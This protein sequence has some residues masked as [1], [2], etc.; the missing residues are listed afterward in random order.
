MSASAQDHNHFPDPHVT[1]PSPQ[2]PLLDHVPQ[3]HSHAELPSS[4]APLLLHPPPPPRPLPPLV[5]SLCTSSAHTLHF[6]LFLPPP[7]SLC[8]PVLLS[9]SSTPLRPSSSSPPF[10][11]SHPPAPLPTP[12]FQLSSLYI[13]ARLTVRF[14]SQAVTIRWMLQGGSGACSVSY[15]R[16]ISMLEAGAE[17]Q[18]ELAC[19]DRNTTTSSGHSAGSRVTCCHMSCQARSLQLEQL[20]PEEEPNIFRGCQR[21]LLKLFRPQSCIRPLALA[22]SLPLAPSPAPLAPSM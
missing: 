9:P 14:E 1:A 2:P 7:V 11:F 15:S 12:P 18:R 13:T 8:I 21:V 6:A 22:R 19:Y 5:I 4:M 3:R 20:I 10:L 17:P 16:Q